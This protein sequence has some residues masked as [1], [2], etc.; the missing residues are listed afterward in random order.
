MSVADF[1]IELP[2]LESLHD[3]VQKLKTWRKLHKVNTN[4]LC[5][6]VQMLEKNI[7]NVI[8]EE[9]Q[10]MCRDIL[11]DEGNE[12]AWDF[13]H[14]RLVRASYAASTSL[15][16]MTAYKIPKAVIAEDAIERAAQ[17]CK[18]L[19]VHVICPAADTIVWNSKGKKGDDAKTRR[20]Q[21]GGEMFVPL[22]HAMYI[23][24]V[25]MISCFSDFVS[26]GFLNWNFRSREGGLR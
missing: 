14:E 23:G 10:L 24:I 8:D 19:L 7:E 2:L 26:F 12:S 13:F 18:Q 9:G 5:V 20:R 11:E 21:H 3:E 25:D 1:L 15:I 22:V 4:R 6:L 17:L 16:I